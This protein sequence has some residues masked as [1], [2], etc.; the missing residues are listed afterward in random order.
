MTRFFI[1]GDAIP[2]KLLKYC[3]FSRL[4]FFSS[5]K[6]IE[7]RFGTRIKCQESIPFIRHHNLFPSPCSHPLH[8]SHFQWFKPFSDFLFMFFFFYPERFSCIFY[9]LSSQSLSLVLFSLALYFIYLRTCWLPARLVAGLSAAAAAAAFSSTIAPNAL[10]LFPLVP[11]YHLLFFF[12]VY[13]LS[14]FAPVI[15]FVPSSLLVPGLQ[16]L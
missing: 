7:L 6:I 10:N 16:Y 15:C 11:S 14:L 4:F 8:L 13:F 1:K 12:C 2:M 9:A 3:W 5:L